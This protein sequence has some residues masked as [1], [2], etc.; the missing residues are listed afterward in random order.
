MASK[1]KVK[2]RHYNQ[3]YIQYGFIPSP[4][5]KLKPMCLLCKKILSNE[6]MK[7]SRL[8]YHL[9]NIHPDKA[10]KN[11]SFFKDLRDGSKQNTIKH[12]FSKSVNNLDD[13]LR[14]TYHLSALIAEQGLPN[15]VGEKALL[16]AIEVVLNKVL[17]HKD[18]PGIIRSIPLSDDTV[19][20]RIDEMSG[21]V[22]NQLIKIL[23][24]NKFSIQIDESTLPNNNALLLMY[25]R[26]IKEGKLCEELAAVELLQLI[27]QKRT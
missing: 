23:E 14:A 22:E 24:T 2:S 6:A 9:K 27:Q 5:D 20:R 16:P 15:T 8:V 21:D 26:F 3:N 1:L 25:V 13:G 11:V 18:T 12:M 4:S 17:H 7:P 19:R 10:D